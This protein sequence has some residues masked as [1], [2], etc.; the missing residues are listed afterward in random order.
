VHGKVFTVQVVDDGIGMA[1]D[2]ARSGLVNLASRAEDLGGSLR[3]S[4]SRS[5]GTTVVWQVPY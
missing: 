4:S 5:G 2:A 1:R 3:V